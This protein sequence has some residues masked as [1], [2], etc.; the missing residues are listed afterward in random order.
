VNIKDKPFNPKPSLNPNCTLNLTL[1]LKITLKPTLMLSLML[2]L[3][4]TLMLTLTQTLNLTPK[5]KLQK[6]LKK[7]K[8]KK[9]L[10]TKVRVKLKSSGIPDVKH[11]HY[12]TS[13]MP[14]AW[15]TDLFIWIASCHETECSTGGTIALADLLPPESWRWNRHYLNWYQNIWSI[16]I[17]QGSLTY[18]W[19]ASQMQI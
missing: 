9:R 18:I 10:V 16:D 2:T 3:I 7:V 4:L 8:K 12:A 14:I 11:N 1:T 5:R 19:P 17:G 6:V 15:Q 13:S